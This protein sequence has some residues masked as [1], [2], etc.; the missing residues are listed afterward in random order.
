MN[1]L[2][3]K[4]LS[5]TLFWAFCVL[6]PLSSL[7][8][9]TEPDGQL[10][11]RCNLNVEVAADGQQA[12]RIEDS[13]KGF[14]TEARN[15]TYSHQFVDPDHLQRNAFFFDNLKGI[16]TSQN[17][18]DHF[19][20]PCILKSYSFD[21]K[22]YYLTL[23]ISGNRNGSPFVN[24][25]FE[26]KASPYQG[27]YRFFCLFDDRTEHLKTCK[28]R[29]VT[30]HYPSEFDQKK[31]ESFVAFRD[32]FCKL[33]KTESTPL[34]YFHFRSL[35]EALMAY[36]FLFDCQK[37]NDLSND[38]GRCDNLGSRFFTGMDDECNIDDYVNAHLLNR[39]PKRDEMYRG[40][41]EGIAVVYGN[42]WGGVSVAEMKIR[43]LEAYENNP[44]MNFL[45]EFKKGRKSHVGP[46][47]TF[48]F[49]C[50]LFCEKLIN[51][52]RFDAAIRLLY[53]GQKGE[54][55]FEN[56]DKEMGINESNFHETVLRLMNE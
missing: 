27:R 12:K 47:F 26:I 22:D 36:G 53:S 35:E 34:E 17:V 19:E 56:L 21:S 39:L 25:I 48:F 45:D 40:I 31:T 51:E 18:N 54:R 7:Y 33:T 30:F 23:S 14:L 44:K 46:H 1:Q 49:V 38:L 10:Q 5:S 2:L 37:C 13:L 28:I 32:R 24:K 16:C 29:N 50:A 41:R 4:R 8:G 3:S 42:T 11:I 9:Q 15:G 6:Y 52:D 20:A 43:F 55:F